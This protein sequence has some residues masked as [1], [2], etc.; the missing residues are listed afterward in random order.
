P[1][2]SPPNPPTAVSAAAGNAQATVQ[3]T[4]PANTGGSPIT[5]YTVT[6]TDATNG[7]IGRPTW[8]GTAR[9][10]TVGGLTNGHSATS[11][12]TATKALGTGAPSAAPTAI[13]PAS[14]PG[15]P[16]P[17]SAAA[18]NAQATIQFT[19]PANT[20]GSPITGYTVTATDAT[21]G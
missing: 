13:V 20:G 6:A 3:F 19:P 7:E 18:G 2:A 10:T 14:P 11:T 15:A 16:A 4:P 9:P 8:T 1:T 5:G 21:N 12:T 17:V